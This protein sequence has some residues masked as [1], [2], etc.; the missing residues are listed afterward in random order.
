M[1]VQRISQRVLAWFGRIRVAREEIQSIAEEAS[2]LDD[3]ESIPQKDA[4][5]L[6]EVLESV[7]KDADEAIQKI[8]EVTDG[9]DASSGS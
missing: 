3:G 4:V 9:R 8:R 6:T 5:I 1:N 7:M 2:H